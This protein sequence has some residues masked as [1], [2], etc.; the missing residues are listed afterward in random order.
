MKFYKLK[1]IKNFTDIFRIKE[2][3]ALIHNKRCYKVLP[4]ISTFFKFYYYSGTIFLVVLFLFLLMPHIF[5]NLYVQILETIITYIFIEYIL[6]IFL[7]L[8]EVKC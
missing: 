7:P 3:E 5:D 6:I 2:G 8:K 4:Y 1:Y